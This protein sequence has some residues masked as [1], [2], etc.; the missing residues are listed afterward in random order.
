ML[1]LPN[2][3]FAVLFSRLSIH[4]IWTLARS[5]HAQYNHIMT[6]SQC[7]DR[8]T[9]HES[10]GCWERIIL[11]NI[12]P[13]HVIIGKHSMHIHTV[14]ISGGELPFVRRLIIVKRNRLSCNPQLLFH[15]TR[16]KVPSSY[17][18][19]S[20]DISNKSLVTGITRL[21]CYN[22]Q[23]IKWG[24]IEYLLDQ[25]PYLERFKYYVGTIH[26]LCHAWNPTIH[27]VIINQLVIVGDWR[28]IMLLTPNIQYNCRELTLVR[29]KIYKIIH[30]IINLTTLILHDTRVAITRE[31]V[32]NLTRVILSGTASFV[33][34]DD[35][36]ICYQV[37]SASD[38]L[39]A[40]L[41]RK[42]SRVPLI[43]E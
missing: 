3:I 34:V 9:I 40:K 31:K 25:S 8:A 10:I 15:V 41:A 16:L 28:L 27:K 38:I 23:I 13:A 6:F 22:M 35:A 43:V 17:E 4:D 30:P 5:S 32:P 20:V 36:N 1:H 39:S 19:I 2:D 26:G 18:N 42:A 24:S 7:V 21:T 29:C 14:H 37:E 11:D 33:L 12:Q